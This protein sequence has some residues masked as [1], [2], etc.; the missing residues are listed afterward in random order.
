MEHFVN[1]VGQKLIRKNVLAADDLDTFAYGLDMLLFSLATFAALLTLGGIAGYLWETA[2]LAAVFS[3]LQS[4]GGGYHAPTHLRCFCTM[5]VGWG[6]GILLIR[7][8]PAPALFLP[9][10]FG[11]LSVMRFAPIENANAPMRPEKKIR[12]KLLAHRLISVFVLVACASYFVSARVFS[13]V[14]TA[15][16]MAGLSQWAATFLPRLRPRKIL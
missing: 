8:T 3:A 4:I 9:L 11:W 16:G 13:A 15:G 12:M 7:Y 6:A 5:L 2:L 1:R 10:A 14:A